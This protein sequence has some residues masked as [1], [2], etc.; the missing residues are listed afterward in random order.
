MGSLR[1]AAAIVLAFTLVAS[2]ASSGEEQAIAVNVS[3]KLQHI[4]GGTDA[5][6]DDPKAVS[7]EARRA[8]RISYAKAEVDAKMSMLA[9]KYQLWNYGATAAMKVHSDGTYVDSRP[10]IPG[11]ETK[12]KKAF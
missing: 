6:A 12:I 2:I 8:D 9:A 1:K 10:T 11:L 5:V 3:G 7:E 4:G